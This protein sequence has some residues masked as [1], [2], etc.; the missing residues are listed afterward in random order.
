MG[1]EF[2]TAP[3]PPFGAVFTYHLDEDIKTRAKTRRAAEQEIE[4]DNGDTPYPSWE[5]LRTEDREEAPTILLVVK[6]SGGNVVRQV[7]G[8]TTAGL[9]RT[10]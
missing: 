4:K 5:A 1:A 2:F 3:N 8:E 10:A 9:H 7:Q 6:D